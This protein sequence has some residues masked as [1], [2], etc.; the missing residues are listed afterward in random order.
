LPEADGG[1]GGGP[2]FADFICGLRRE[3]DELTRIE[4]IVEKD[5]TE[6]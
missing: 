2:L 6:L 3:F 4:L 5:P 1:G